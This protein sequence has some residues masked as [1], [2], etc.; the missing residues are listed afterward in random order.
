MS[1]QPEELTRLA[2]ALR[3]LCPAGAIDR[4]E[5]LYR[6]GRAAA[7]RRGPWVAAT[8]VATLV[9]ATLAVV[10]AVRPPTVIERVREAPAPAAPAEELPTAPAS[11]WPHLDVQDRLITHGLD[12]LG[13]RRPTRPSI[14][15]PRGVDVP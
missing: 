10:L 1:E 5:L 8:G 12:G 13:E 6:A 14:L 4:D 3:R 11:P 2:Q 9:A 7:P 15:P